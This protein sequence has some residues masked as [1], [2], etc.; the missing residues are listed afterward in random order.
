MNITIAVLSTILTIMMFIH[1][2]TICL[3]IKLVK[4]GW[5]IIN[6]PRDTEADKMIDEL[7]LVCKDQKKENEYLQKQLDLAL[8]L[9]DEA[10]KKLPKEEQV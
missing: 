6:P 3:L 9:Y 4:K 10:N 5:L 1:I 8:E 2:V 7:D